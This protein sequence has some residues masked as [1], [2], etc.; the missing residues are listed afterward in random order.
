MEV[1]W[2]TYDTR[3][4]NSDVM[5]GC[6]NKGTN[7]IFFLAFFST[8]MSGVLM[9]NDGGVGFPPYYHLLRI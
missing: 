1:R 9:S 3:I 2:I 4:Q 8:D 5:N 6:R 7:N